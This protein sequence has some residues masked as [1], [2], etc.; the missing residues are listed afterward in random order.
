[1]RYEIAD[2]LDNQAMRQLQQQVA[3]LTAENEQLKKQLGL[4][5]K[6]VEILG[7]PHLI[8]LI[9][10]ADGS[11]FNLVEAKRM[12]GLDLT[13]SEAALAAVEKE[14]LNC[15]G[16]LTDKKMCPYA[17]GNMPCGYMFKPKA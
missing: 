9:K 15:V 16:C 4:A 11:I 8:G 2:E 12:A 10:S 6:I 17:I 5:C 1:M 7:P 13:K 14:I 3:D